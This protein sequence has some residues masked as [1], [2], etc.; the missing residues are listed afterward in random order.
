LQVR[1]LADRVITLAGTFGYDRLGHVAKSLGDLTNMLLVLGA[2]PV[3]PIIVHI[4]S[5]WLFT[6][7]AEVLPVDN[8]QKVLAE[9]GRVLEHFGLLA[10]PEQAEPQIGEEPRP[11]R[12]R[13]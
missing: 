11:P 4:R 6:P 8:A 9:L 5:A 1:E 10:L 13:N 2:G 12:L 3:D 7:R